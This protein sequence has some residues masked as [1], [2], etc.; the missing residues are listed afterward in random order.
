M[1]SPSNNSDN[2]PPSLLKLVGSLTQRDVMNALAERSLEEFTKQAWTI[3]E[4][5]TPYVHGW[6][7][8]AI[9]EHL[10][11]VS[12]NQINNL[13]IT[14]PPGHMKS[15][16]TCVF[17]PS[18]A[19][20]GKPW[21][22]WMFA[23]YAY[24]L[25]ARDSNK[26]RDLIKSAWY[27]E[28]WGDRYALKVDHESR[29]E[30]DRTGFRIA[31]SVGGLGTGE[32]VHINVNDD[33][34]RA[35]DA[36]SD[37]ERENA[38]DHLKAMA[39]RAVNPATYGQVLIMQRLHT[40]D[41]AGYV[42]EL[43][44]WEHLNLPAE[45]DPKRSKVTSIGWKDPR[46]K[47]GELLWPEMYPANEI[48][49]LKHNLG[50]YGASGQLQQNP[51]PVEGGLIKRKWWRRFDLSRR[52]P[53]YS[54]LLISADPKFKDYETES[55]VAIH[56]WGLVGTDCYLLA[57]KYDHLGLIGTINGILSLHNDWHKP[58]HAVGPTL[59]EDKAN[60]PAIIEALRKRLPG[61]I[62]IEPDGSKIARAMAVSPYIEAGNVWVP[63]TPWG[64]EFIDAWTFMPNGDN[65]DDIDAASQALRYLFRFAGVDVASIMRAN[66]QAPTMSTQQ[67]EPAHEVLVEA[68][69][70]ESAHGGW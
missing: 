1:P 67:Q 47:E 37:A 16:E 51:A 7:V 55:K 52:P 70:M 5:N 24:P 23:S 28:R 14:V 60:G 21:L 40:K 4:P 38:I 58:E 63:E 15:L 2:L 48:A 62:A 45:Y 17:W 26:T 42:M 35:Q 13:L 25:S 19:W 53:S 61:L 41:P 49:K 12:S 64:E 3:L 18:W 34:L 11:A 32:R 8:A 27:Q 65:W 68:G 66:E 44:G 57:R 20:I 50:S 56:V 54:Q 59:V 31:T 36:L 33:L 29:V 6:H 46:Q 10:E 9:A 43:G 22:R 69:M 30:N 39:T